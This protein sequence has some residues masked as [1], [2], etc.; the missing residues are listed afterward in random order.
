MLVPTRPSGMFNTMHS[1]RPIL[2]AISVLTLASSSFGLPDDALVWSDEFNT[3]GGPDPNVWSYD[4]G[5]GQWGWGNQELQIYTDSPDNVAVDGGQLVITA[6]KTDDGT[7]TSARIRSQDKIMFQYGTVEARIRIP[8]LANGLWPAFWTLGNDFSVAG[9]PHCG[10]IDV[11]EMGEAGAIASG[12]VNRRV[13]STAHWDIGGNHASYGLSLTLP[14]DLDSEFH[15]WRLEWTPEFIRTFVDDQ[16]IWTIDISDPDGFS[17]HEFHAPHF[18]ILNLAVGGNFTGIN[19]ENGITAPLP[20]Q[21]LID[22][23]RLYDNGH[24]LL[25][26]P[27]HGNLCAADVNEDG[28]VGPEDLALLLAAWNTNDPM[29]DLDGSGTVDAEDLS[30][31]IGTWGGCSI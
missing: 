6:R 29:T 15:V 11:L 13:Y 26:G 18:F 24:T 9:W 28:I 19:Q 14:E 31:L 30:V 8:D 16:P 10:E 7:I 23:V 1:I 3:N 21:Y 2:Y 4:I 12:E 17:G 22:Y 25:S 20:A 27:G 5:T